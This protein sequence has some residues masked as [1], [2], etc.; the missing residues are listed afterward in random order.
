MKPHLDRLA[1]RLA[2]PIRPTEKGVALGTESIEM[3]HSAS[4]LWGQHLPQSLRRTGRLWQVGQLHAGASIDG[5]RQNARCL[6]KCHSG[7]I[8]ADLQLEAEGSLNT[9]PFADIL[10][11]LLD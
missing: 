6:L 8:A 3:T 9:Q 4:H 11:W 5:K 1:D 10:P 7:K 2:A